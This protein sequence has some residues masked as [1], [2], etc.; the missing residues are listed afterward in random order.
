[1]DP[2]LSDPRITERRVQLSYATGIV[3]N[4][5]V[6]VERK[7]KSHK[8]LQLGLLGGSFSEV[9]WSYTP[10]HQLRI[11]PQQWCVISARLLGRLGLL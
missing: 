10:L 3:P 9:Q 4:E 11:W 6:R 1:M 2:T 8:L 5:L 7:K